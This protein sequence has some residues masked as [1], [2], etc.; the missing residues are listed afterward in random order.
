MGRMTWRR[1]LAGLLAVGGL[2][3]PAAGQD[4]PKKVIVTRPAGVKPGV[5]VVT[6]EVAPARPAEVVPASAELLPHQMPVQ[7]AANLPPVIS[8]VPAPAAP[9]PYQPV[10]PP[11][12]P[13][14]RRTSRP[15]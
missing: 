1:L 6:G 8:E 4:A 12:Q 10:V 9:M 11:Y 15:S 3:G 14:S 5:Y 2:A 7:P 13:R